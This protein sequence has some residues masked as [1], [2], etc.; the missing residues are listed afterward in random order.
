MKSDKKRFPAAVA[1]IL[2]SLS[3]LAAC[4]TPGSGVVTPAPSASMSTSPA[5]S[6]SGLE[7]TLAP[8]VS[9]PSPQPT[10]T[11]SSAP[12]ITPTAEPSSEPSTAPTVVATPVPSASHLVFGKIFVIAGN[13]K[14]GAPETGID[15]KE[16]ALPDHLS[17]IVV[18]KQNKIWMLN[19][20]TGI[21]GEVTNIISR[22]TSE[23]GTLE[24]RLYWDRAK[25]LSQTSGMAYD[26]QHHLF[27][28]VQQTTNQVLRYDP[29]SKDITVFAG[30]GLSGYN[31]DRAAL[32]TQFSQPSDVALDSSGNLYVTDTGNHLVRKI[33]ADGQVTTIAGVYTPDIYVKEEDENPSLIPLGGTTGDGGLANQARVDSP[34]SI[35]VDSAG[36]IYFSSRSNT[37]RSIANGMIKAYAGSGQTGYNGD[38]FRAE[39]VH[40]NQVG[41]MAVGPDGNLYFIDKGNLR[42]RR[43]LF[44]ND[45]LIIE[46]LAGNGQSGSFASVF[47]DP[48]KADILPEN[49]AFDSSGNI[50]IYDQAH[51]RLRQLQVNNG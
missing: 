45:V 23:L 13:G 9:V 27:Y 36:T 17:A 38:G 35:A 4:Q 26:S 24:Y 11:P 39:L 7:P 21:L 51:R 1:S 31:G 25:D 33:S 43:V 32:E 16:I 50:Y 28:I 15:V 14:T 41:D 46:T 8:P 5:P 48:L 29:V 42:V 22:D 30:T 49:I 40:L 10:V 34:S 20:S 18:D 47:D 12:T 37:I 3:L 44:R 6:P 19:N 2:A